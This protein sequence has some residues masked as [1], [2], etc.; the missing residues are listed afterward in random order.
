MFNDLG[1]IAEFEKPVRKDGQR[2]SYGQFMKDGQ[3]A[4]NESYKAVTGR[5][6]GLADQ[7]ITT[8]AHGESFPV[9][10][11]KKKIEGPF[12]TL[13]PPVTPQDFQ[14]AGKAI[15]TKVENAL[16]G[17]DPAFVKMQKACA[18]LSKDLKTKVL[19]KL[20][21]PP[22]N[23]GLSPQAQQQALSH[24]QK[25]QKVMDDFATGNSDPFTT[26]KKLEQLTG[27]TNMEHNARE[28]QKLLNKLGGA[29][30]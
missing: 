15:F 7:N 19:D 14:K 20:K 2:V 10:W 5:S 12:T 28:V 18:S 29:T 22:A 17:H 6:A 25:V 8:S 4:Y 27:S 24:W 21:N 16:K 11:L 3:K 23:T 30:N 1:L 9:S 13:D 26:M